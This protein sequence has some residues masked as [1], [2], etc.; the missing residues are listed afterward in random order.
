MIVCPRCGTQNVSQT[1][2][3]TLC[4]HA[5]DAPPATAE[6]ARPA[7]GVD[8]KRTLL[9][10]G[11]IQPVIPPAAPQAE[12]EAKPPSLARSGTIIGLASPVQDQTPAPQG[13]P[14]AG[15]TPSGSTLPLGRRT[16]MGLAPPAPLVAN[17]P[18]SAPP[19]PP[20][21]PPE[22]DADA[23]AGPEL[24][25][26]NLGG[27]LVMPPREVSAPSAPPGPERPSGP[28]A[29]SGPSKT[30]LG[31]ARP[32]IAPLN[33][34]VA[35]TAPPEAFPSP[36]PPPPAAAPLEPEPEPPKTRA[37]SLLAV[38]VILAA[39]LLLAGGLWVFFSLRGQGPIEAKA[40]L[41]PDG[42]E[43]LELV[44][45][46]C[47]DG[48]R[49]QIGQVAST[50]RG[51]LAQLQVPSELKVGDNRFEL[52]LTP[53]GS[54]RENRI[55]ITVPLEYRVRGDVSS[56]TQA[57]PSLS[58]RVEA[59]PG[60]SV[61]VDG[62]PV[63]LPANGR[64]QHLIDVSR[65][66]TGLEPNVRKLERR[67][68]Y[69]IT[70]PGRPA[71][72]GEVSIQLGIPPLSIEAPGDSIVIE[73]PTFVLSGKTAKGGALSIGERPIPVDADGRFV[74]TLSVSALG[75]TNVTLRATLPDF[76]PRLFTFRVRRV[77]SL[78]DEGRAARASATASYEAIASDIDQKRGWK[79]ALDGSVIELGGSEH[80]SLFLLD[81]KSGCKKPPCTVKVV[82][83]ARLSLKLGDRVSVFGLVRGAV[84]GP[85]AGSQVPEVAADFVVKGQR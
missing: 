50:F 32:G 5:L 81:V 12:P 7:K 17:A 59:V 24:A 65:E 68:Q 43:R 51:G 1:S 82:H 77:A 23:D 36:P 18:G 19:S 62:H 85:R 58:V 3:C 55:A 28:I 13:V 38:G 78:A 44:C 16:V 41:A 35:K 31:V 39:V 11:P 71:R 47:K 25:R 33:P 74:Q 52:A 10:Q 27:T 76:A 60:S 70:P 9:G 8:F 30:I 63:P 69:V 4:G 22:P 29:L 49:V 46:N 14:T 48:E 64:A 83:G 26:P 54:T 75:E 72:S 79:V 53:P 2:A 42:H 66:L 20:P 84:D 80:S 21:P 61:V 40:G 73:T 67:I 34:G 37:A 57:A 6:P 45:T 56:L 15:P